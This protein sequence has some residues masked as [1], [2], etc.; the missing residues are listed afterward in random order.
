MLAGVN[1]RYVASLPTDGVPQARLFNILSKLNTTATLSSGELPMR[2]F[3][4]TAVFL[5]L[6]QPGESA[7]L[8]GYLDRLG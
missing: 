7:T 6:P 3:L 1:P 8:Q 4:S 2:E 5:T